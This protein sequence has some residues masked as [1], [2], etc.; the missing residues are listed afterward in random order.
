MKAAVAM[1]RQAS[2]VKVNGGAMSIPTVADGEERSHRRP[3]EARGP[4]SKALFG[5]R[6]FYVDRKHTAVRHNNCSDGGH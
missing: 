3:R 5:M 1:G 4:F 2:T 6:A